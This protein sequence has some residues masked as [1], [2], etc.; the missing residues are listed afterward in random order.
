MTVESPVAKPMGVVVNAPIARPKSRL[1]RFLRALLRTTI[2]ILALYCATR[3]LWRYSGSNQW[4]LTE[5][6]KGAK[7]WTLKQPG[8]DLKLVK[9]SVQVRSSLSTIVAW[10]QDPEACKDAGCVDN[11]VERI[12][13]QLEYEYFKI[14]MRP[15]F[16]PRD[17]L[18][19]VD[20]HQVPQTRELWVDYA[21]APDRK[22]VDACCLR[23]TN[24]N[25]SWRFTPLANGMVEAEYT[26]N[27]DWGGFI[28]DVLSNF[29]KP[30]YLLVQ[31][32]QLQRF[33]DKEKYRN[34]SYAFIQ[35]AP[36]APAAP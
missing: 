14:A 22:P 10:L 34:A 31:L 19:R 11:S 23:V 28:P 13:D 25:T 9:G 7:V 26:M 6:G 32:Q 4:E 8:S 20:F 12:S 29:A 16:K 17:F 30:K 15:P 18:L 21:A 35:E 1:A 36:A 27:M 5:E 2:W 33:L 24:M 3:L